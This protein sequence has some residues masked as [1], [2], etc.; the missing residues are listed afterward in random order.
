MLVTE[1]TQDFQANSNLM[2]PESAPFYLLFC[3]AR[4]GQ[5]IQKKALCRG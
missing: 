3:T 5:P 4:Q 1:K 2:Q